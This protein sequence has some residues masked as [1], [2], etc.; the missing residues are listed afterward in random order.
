MS[1]K[2]F[3]ASL[4]KRAAAKLDPGAAIAAP[5]AIA[6]AIVLPDAGREAIRLRYSGY[7]TA[8]FDYA[9]VRDFCDSFDHLSPLLLFNGDLKDVQRPWTV[10]AVLATTPPGSRLIEIGGG[11]PRAATALAELGY[12]VTVVDP[13]DGAGNGPTEYERYV[14]QYPGVQIIKDRFGVDLPLEPASCGAIFS[15]SVLEHLPASEV[16]NVFAGI[17]KFLRPGGH[18]IHCIDSVIGGNDTEYHYH[19]LKLIL[20]EQSKL[21]RPE[22]TPDEMLPDEMLPDEM[23]PDETLYDRLLA[24]LGGDLE[25]FYLSAEGHN[26][27]RGGTSYDDFPFRKVVSIQTCVHSS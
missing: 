24:Q 5:T 7:Q 20:H 13:Y 23:L 17:R 25:T 10:K 26:L 15:I 18:S 22:Q 16:A 4:L 11:E 1:R 9:T 6:P 14:K 8:P 2:S 12:H 27:W 3:F 19:Q 21:I